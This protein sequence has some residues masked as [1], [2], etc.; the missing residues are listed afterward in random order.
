MNQHGAYVVSCAG[1]YRFQWLN[2][3]VELVDSLLYNKNHGDE[4]GPVGAEHPPAFC[5]E[6]VQFTNDER[7][8]KTLSVHQLNFRKSAPGMGI[9][10][11]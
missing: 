1:V 11:T 2:D 10:P 6:L 4:S 5:G 9:E 3:T 8:A 7:P